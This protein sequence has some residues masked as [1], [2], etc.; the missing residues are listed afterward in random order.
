[1]PA[2]PTRNGGRATARL[3]GIEG[4]ENKAA[5]TF[6]ALIAEYKKSPEWTELSANDRDEWTRYFA[7]V[8]EKWG[9]LRVASVE[10]RHVLALR[11]SF[12]DIP[13]ADARKHTKPLED[14]ANRPAAANNLLRALSS[15]MS[16]SV[17][18]GWIAANPCLGVKKLKGGTPYE[19]WSWEAICLFEKEARADAVACG[20]AR[21]LYRAALGRCAEDALERHPRGHDRASSRTRP[22]RSSG[23]RCTRR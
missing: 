22:G 8:E 10:P 23:F 1:M 15:M 13:P 16:W 11:D 4:E 12:A 9:S 7:H 19:P 5:G 20:G 14:Y 2:R 18:R 21:S 17:P 3:A 6:A